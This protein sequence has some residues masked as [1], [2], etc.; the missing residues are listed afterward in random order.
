MKRSVLIACSAIIAACGWSAQ[1]AQSAVKV[2]VLTCDI[3]GGRDHIINVSKKVQCGY[4]PNSGRPESYT[5]TISKVGAGRGYIG[6]G[7]ITWDVVAPDAEIGPGALQGRYGRFDVDAAA[8]A[9]G[10]LLG[11]SGISIALHPVIVEGD[12]RFDKFVAEVQG[13]TLKF[14]KD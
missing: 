9:G 2:G 14:A 6:K 11:G 13:L 1:A 5:G 4:M 10:P 7:A 12:R 8:S 3:D